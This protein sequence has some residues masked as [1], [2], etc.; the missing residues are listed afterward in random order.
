MARRA[1]WSLVRCT[2]WMLTVRCRRRDWRRRHTT[3]R[4]PSTILALQLPPPPPAAG[5]A[6]LQ[7]RQLA[8]SPRGMHQA[9]E[10]V[11]AHGKERF[12]RVAAFVMICGAGLNVLPAVAAQSVP[13]CLALL[14]AQQPF[15]VK[16]GCSRL[17]LLMRL[18]AGRQKAVE[19]GAPRKLLSLV[20]RPDLDA[21]GQRMCWPC[22]AA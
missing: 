15:M 5:R 19:V 18:E 12:V 8:T 14:D 22:N 17:V 7:L 4:R 13:N 1:A 3:R 10:A 9:A 16:A 2:G 20:K 11:Q 6:L 21:G